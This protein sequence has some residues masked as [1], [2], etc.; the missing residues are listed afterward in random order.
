VHEH[1]AATLAL[2]EP[3]ALGVVEPLDLACDAH[4]S[5]SLLARTAVAVRLT[6]AIP[7]PPPSRRVLRRHHA[8]A[9]PKTEQMSFGAQKKDR[10]C[11]RG[12]DF[13]A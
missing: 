12:L 11:L 10:E 8:A 13:S 5:S 6:R 9:R 1:V 7:S 2:N 3:V 4:R